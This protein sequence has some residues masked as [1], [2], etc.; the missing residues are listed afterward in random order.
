MFKLKSTFSFCFV[1]GCLETFEIAF[2]DEEE[3]DEGEEGGEQGEVKNIPE[4]KEV[5]EED[6]A[7][8]EELF[9]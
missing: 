7:D 2:D 9:S 5:E 1:F 6:D 3:E 4:R 8:V